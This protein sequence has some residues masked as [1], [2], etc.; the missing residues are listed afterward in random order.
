MTGDYSG[1]FDCRLFRISRRHNSSL[2]TFLVVSEM[3]ILIVMNQWGEGNK[4]S[5]LVARM[6]LTGAS[7]KTWEHM[8][9]TV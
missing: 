5:H 7:I 6:G 1:F 9:F 2:T 4:G 8:E 3:A